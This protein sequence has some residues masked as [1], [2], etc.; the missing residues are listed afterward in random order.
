M[1]TH[2]GENTLTMVIT[3]YNKCTLQNSKC[4]FNT[5]IELIQYKLN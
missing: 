2:F 5:R 1:F 4:L 3:T